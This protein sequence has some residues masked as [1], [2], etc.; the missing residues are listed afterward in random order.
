M[1]HFS[2]AKRFG[3]PTLTDFEKGSMSAYDYAPEGRA[4]SDASTTIQSDI[5]NESSERER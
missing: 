3:I 2:F 1:S 5:I 4:V